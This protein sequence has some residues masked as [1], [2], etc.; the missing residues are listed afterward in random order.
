MAA[1]AEVRL[2]AQTGEL[3]SGMDD[4]SASVAAS[5][6]QIATAL[7]KF[8]AENRKTTEQALK[9]NA[10]L[11]RS[12]LELKG[13][14]T[15]GF[16]AIAGVIERFRG[17]IGS[18]GAA[19]AGGFIGKEAIAALV[20]ERDA[21]HGLQIVF[22]AT[23]EEATRMNVQ[24]KLAG[25]TAEAFEGMAFRVGRVLRTQSDE[26]DRLGVKTKDANGNLLPM[27][28]I[29][30]N[31]YQRMLDF[32]AGTDQTEF[33]LST[34][35]RNAAEFAADMEKFNSVT[36]RAADLQRELGIEM[37]PEKQAAVARYKVEVNAFK[38]ILE[39]IGQ[40]VGEQLLPGLMRLSEWFSSVGPTAIGYAV[41][42]I[43]GFITATEIVRQALDL[44]YTALKILLQGIWSVVYGMLRVSTE[45]TNLNW[46]GAVDAIRD[47]WNGMK[48]QTDAA[49]TDL[50]DRNRA[51][52]DRINNLWSGV[53]GQQ[54]MHDR[55]IGSEGALPG[56]GTERF[57]QKPTGG[58]GESEISQWEASL[59]ASENYYN[60]LKLQQG[61]FEVWSEEM[62]RDY[63]ATV[64]ASANLS[65][66]DRE[67]ITNKFYD[68]ERRVQQ[69]QFSAYIGNLE[70]EKAALG[71][72]IEAK[73]IIAQKEF[74]AIAQRF[75]KESAE[76]AAANR[77]LIDLR[78]QL[79]D[80]RN[81]IADIEQ[82]S[83]QATFKH[84]IDLAKLG[85]DQQLALRQISA[86][87]R[88][89]V[90]RDFLDKEYAAEVA[91]M[92]ARIALLAAD[93]TSDP[94]KLA[95]L[96]A[97]LL[98][99][100]EDYQ[101]KVTDV[102]N[103]SELERK[104]YVIQAEEA[105]QNT[106]GTLL[107]DLMDRTK[108]WKQ[109]MLDA[110]SSITKALNDLVAKHL[111]E[112]LFGPGTGAN[113]ILGSIFGSLFGG[114]A[115]PSFD[116]GTPYVPRDTLAL[117]HRGERIIP[118]GQNKGGGQGSPFSVVNNFHITGPVDS[119]TQDQIAAAAARA[120]QRAAYRN[121]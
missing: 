67:A 104:Q 60:N 58:G 28:T 107:S 100:E 30:Q 99:V 22:G 73:I 33:A 77:R 120:T 10:D 21:V 40:Q 52:V 90:E 51:A 15:G 47:A 29:I 36:Q 49:M 24:L 18:L 61:S 35:G 13:S 98:K 43:K 14:L 44:V 12:F 76:A 45:L 103:K 119:R 83:Q 116:V 27:E 71:H 62:T 82:R 70:A 88:F 118:A 53:M 101:R 68:A 91:A 117:V 32:K 4:A 46:R 63:W 23:A 92:Q 56:K 54:G 42:A 105:V 110:V 106:F 55:G 89:A 111:A 81:R 9:N 87:Q 114:G 85:A 3:K 11:S 78:Q 38:L 31:I 102:A 93:P 8:G 96:K 5:L 7:D 64:L 108:S 72:N 39:E 86:Q 94:A 20:E 16:N 2:G 37:G 112:Q 74:D 59:K 113:N 65:A 17:V 79:A 69:Q 75:G 41:S 66:K 84:E 26:F 50:V 95:E 57:R 34:V 121:L 48:A 6:Q 109:S 97:Q 19:L 25:I 115:I 80:Q 1:D